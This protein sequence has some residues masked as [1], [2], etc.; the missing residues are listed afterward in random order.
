MF[1]ACDAVRDSYMQVKSTR[2]AL[3]FGMG[4]RIEKVILDNSIWL[5]SVRHL[6][7]QLIL[8]SDYILATCTMVFIFGQ[9]CLGNTSTAET[10]CEANSGRT[11]CFDASK[12]CNYLSTF[13]SSFLY[14]DIAIFAA[15]RQGDIFWQLHTFLKL[16]WAVLR[17]LGFHLSS[18]SYVAFPWAQLAN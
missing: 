11:K 12:S 1:V 18:K 16:A 2:P 14:Y 4:F 7:C 13:Y 6:N 10:S 15:A 5:T 9:K 3:E 8:N 17:A